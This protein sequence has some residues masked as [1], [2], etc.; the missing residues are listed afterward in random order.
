MNLTKLAAVTAVT[1]A[2]VGC[3][4]GDVVIDAS[5]NS[6]NTDNSTNVGGG[7]TT[8]PCASYLTDP[9]DAA[10][11][12]QGTFDGQNCNYDSTFAG[13]DNPLLVNLTI[14][15]IAGAHV[16]EDSLFVGAN[17]DI[18]P[19]PQAPD[20]P[21]A[22]GTV[23]DGVV[24]TIAA[25]A[26]LAWTQSSDY[27]LINRGSQIIADGSPSAP[28]IFTSLSDVNGSVDP[29]A[30]A[31]WGGIVINGNG[32]TNK[33]TDEQ[34]ATDACHVV[35]EG[36]PSNFGGNNNAESSGV[37]RYVQVKHTGF[38]VAD[39]DELN[40]VTFNAVGSGTAVE[41]LQAYS[42]SDD[43]VEFF[44]GAVNVLNYVGLYVNDDSI[45]YA[46]GYVG[47]VTN[48]LVI[49][50]LNTGN[51]CIEGDNIGSGDFN[52]EPR[53]S[54]V[55]NNL[56]CIVS[57]QDGSIRG[58]S[59]GPLYRRGV[60]TILTNSITADSWARL[61]L[62]RE[63]NECFELNNAETYAVAEAGVQTNVTASIIACEEATKD[64]N[65]GAG[66]FTSGE[67]LTSWYTNAAGNSDFNTGTAVITDSINANIVAL[68][69]IY[70][71]PVCSDTGCDFVD[72][73]GNTATIVPAAVTGGATN[74][75]GNPIV[76]AVSA[77]NDWT[78]G[79]TFGLQSTSNGGRLW[80]DPAT[81]AAP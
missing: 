28:I 25:G 9:D 7:G 71:A 55:V 32:I 1:L 22:D 44:G 40:G 6:T 23:P 37:L 51:R 68:N 48:A 39:G 16:F 46:D 43:G 66:F 14:P 36:K 12:V 42:T 69:G 61:N 70:T 79:W 30:V 34:R 35:S 63:G 60:G 19:T 13:E 64:D 26:T 20:A 15:R 75:E 54:P 2:L 47:S 45:D 11:R 80:F 31:Q 50:G 81:G 78:A 57:A 41:N 77:D 17:T 29:E 27:L 4:G 8:N 76:G 62:G 59:E 33:C 3:E 52:Q 49:H 72:D 38:E 18:A 56:T 65:D 73:L 10:T 58:D 74:G 24:L 21:S 5:D 53:T 67:D